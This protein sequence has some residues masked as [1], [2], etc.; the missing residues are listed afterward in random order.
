MAKNVCSVEVCD[1]SARSAGLCPA[2]YERQRRTSR[3]NPDLP[4]RRR[5]AMPKVCTVDGCSSAVAG[6]GLCGLHYS[7]AFRQG[8]RATGLAMPCEVDDCNEPARSRGYCSSHY[9]K[10]RRWG[11]A[12]PEPR[13]RPALKKRDSRSGY[14]WVKAPDNPMAMI[15]GYVAE[16]R[17]VMSQ[18]IGRP[19]EKFENVHHVNGVR[20]DNR[21]ENLELWNTYQPSGQRV[22]DK[23]TW[24]VEILRLYAPERLA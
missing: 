14:V 2:H 3:L 12:T 16:H 20:D 23:V 6:G 13:P 18:A 21:L 10:W 17:L 24:A 11:T 22:P 15:N 4:V 7:Q 8:F 9:A 1:R 5:T 19:L